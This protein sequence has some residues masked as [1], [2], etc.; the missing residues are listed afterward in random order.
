MDASSFILLAVLV[1]ALAAT[2]LFVYGVLVLVFGGLVKRLSRKWFTKRK[3]STPTKLP[4]PLT[5]SRTRS[6]PILK[7]GAYE[8]EKEAVLNPAAFEAHDRT[9]LFYRAVGSDG[10]SRLGYASSA[11]GMQFDE[12]LPYPVYAA[13][14]PRGTGRKYRYDPVRYPSGGS[15]GGTEDPR[16]VVIDTR[17]YVTFNMFDGWDFMRV[18]V[19]SLGIDDLLKKRWNWTTPKFLSKDGERHKNWVL[20]PEKIGGKFAFLHNLHGTHPDRVRIGYTDD[21]GRFDPATVDSPDPNAL[22]SQ[23]RSWHQRM[24]SAGPP[25]IKTVFGWLLFYHATDHESHRYKMG[26]MLLDSEDPEKILARAPSP[27]LVPDASYENE[28]KPGIIYACGATV[29]NGLL[30][31]YYGGGDR[32]VCTATAHLS[33]FAQSLLHNRTPQLRTT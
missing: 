33:S 18:A 2:F 3:K 23:P 16:A 5:L 12:R 27:I 14:D 26:A 24:R 31:I 17:V 19:I 7:Q 30:R 15:W 11:D 21:F 28:G 6:N 20:F 25:P 4:H 13:F 9:H 10:V 32:V 22:P 8:W 29:T 1:G